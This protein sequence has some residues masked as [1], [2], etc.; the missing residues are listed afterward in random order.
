MVNL[1]R[2][3][4]AKKILYSKV[5]IILAFVLLVILLNATWNAYKNARFTKG[6]EERSNHELMELQDR[7]EF[8][9]AKTETLSTPEGIEREIRE[10]LPVAKE[11]EKV[12]ILVEDK[13]TVEEEA[14][15]GQVEESWW[16]RVFPWF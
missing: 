4:K 3:R 14:Q 2:K 16:R 7:A 13:K 8:L 1:E 9:R 12:I 5:T 6:N 11:G 10:N 15:T